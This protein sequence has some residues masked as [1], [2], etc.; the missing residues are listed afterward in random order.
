MTEMI[1]SKQLEFCNILETQDTFMG[2][3]K[4]I[5]VH[6]QIKYKHF[7]IIYEKGVLLGIGHIKKNRRC[8]SAWAYRKQEWAF[9][10]I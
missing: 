6:I 3:I 10:I 9:C 2:H 7:A 1:S 8:V 4:S 5:K